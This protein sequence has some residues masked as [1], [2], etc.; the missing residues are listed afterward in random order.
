MNAK[1][2][3]NSIVTSRVREDGVIEVTVLRGAADGSNAVLTLD[4]SKVSENN[5]RTAMNMG[6]VSRIVDKA[7]LGYDKAK[8]MYATPQDKFAAMAPIVEWLESGAEEWRPARAAVAPRG[9]ALDLILLAAVVEATGRTEL[10]IREKV[11]AGAEKRGVGQPAYLAALGTSEAV[12][13]IA[14][15]LRAEMLARVELSGDDEL[16]ELMKGD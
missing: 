15:R 11:K 9:A 4:P 14:A 6:F 13:P 8:G 5:R 7:A 1:P 10:E 12:A 2:K 3:T 16:D